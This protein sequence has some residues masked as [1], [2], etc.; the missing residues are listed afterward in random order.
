MDR[1]RRIVARDDSPEPVLPKGKPP[2]LCEACPYHPV[3]GTLRKHDCI[4]A[5]DIGC[6]T[7][8]ALPP[9][10]GMDS[11]VAMGASLGVG[12]G[13]RHVLPEKDAKRVVSIIGDSTFIHTGV[14]GLIEMVYNPPATGHVLIVLDNGTTAMTGQQEHPGTGRTLDHDQTGKVSIEGLA[15]AVGVKNVNIV[16]PVSDPA[17]FEKLLVDGLAKPELSMIVARRA[18]IL[19]A[20]DIRKFEKAA[21]DACA[22]CVGAENA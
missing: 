2:M 10:H 9:Y 12:L 13:L 3:Y 15:R 17:G 20:A 1:V 22:A 21:T 4:V 5:G 18:C 16:D 11:C 19:A 7:L 8:G 6:Y 14:N